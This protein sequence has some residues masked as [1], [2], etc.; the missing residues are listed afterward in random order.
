MY[1][2]GRWVICVNDR[3]QALVEFVLVLPIF[4]MIVFVIVDFGLIF[5][6]KNEL[7]NTSFDIVEMVRND[8]DIDSIKSVYPDI[9]I[10]IEEDNEYIRIKIS[11][12]INLITPG[13]SRILDDPYIVKV[14]RTISNV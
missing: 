12:E 6:M 9:S 11:D 7:E 2:I 10:N 5:S 8:K 1:M 4:L 13:A 14:E 3:G